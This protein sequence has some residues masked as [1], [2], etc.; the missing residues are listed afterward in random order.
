MFH[1][2]RTW[3]VL[4]LISASMTS[5]SNKSANSSLPAS[6]ST[7]AASGED[8]NSFTA[9]KAEI[10]KATADEK[11]QA[12]LL[13]S[14][15]CMADK[16]YAEALTALQAAQAAKDSEVVRQ[17]IARV[18]GLIL[19]QQSFEETVTDIQAVIDQGQGEQAAQLAILA[20]AQFG[21]GPEAVKLAALKRQADALVA[22]RNFDT[23]KLL[24]RLRVEA[25]VALKENN[26]R[27]AVV[28]YE[29]MVALKDDPV[30]QKQLEVSRTRL[31]KYESAME[32]AG[33][34]RRNMASLDEAVTAY[35]EATQAWDTLQARSEL[36]DVQLALENRRER[37]AVANFEVRGDASL[38]AFG[39]AFADELLPLLKQRYDLVDRGQVDR[40][41]EELKIG[42]D[43]LVVSEQGRTDLGKLTKT[44]YLV[45]GS[46]TPLAGVTVHARMIDL[47]SGLI[48]QTGKIVAPTPEAAARQLPQLAAQ[49]LMS[50]EEKLAY[51]KQQWQLR[52]PAV[53]SMAESSPSLPV[54]NAQSMPAAINYS[55]AR[56]PAYGTLRAEE[57]DQL[58]PMIVT[59]ST[60]PMYAAEQERP[61]RLRLLAIQLELGDNLYCRG[62][63]REALARFQ[64]A[65]ELDPSNFDILT[66]VDQC[67]VYLPPMTVQPV[68]RDRL[69]LLNF[70]VSGDPRIASPELSTWTPE[71]LMPNFAAGY[72]VI[73][74]GE[75]YWMMSRLGLTLGDVIRDSGVRR[76]FGRALG[77]RYLVIGRIQDIGGLT[78][79]TSLL[80][81]EQGWEAGRG[82]VVVHHL[83]ELKL[84]LPELARMTMAS[85]A[86]RTRLEQ[87]ATQ[88]EADYLRAQEAYQRGQFGL[89]LEIAGRLQQRQP[90]NIRIGFLFNQCDDRT[91]RM[92]ME[93]ARL[94]EIERQ[95]GLVELAAR[96]QADLILAAEQAR[97]E[98]MQQGAKWTE[99]DR[100]KQRDQAQTQLLTQARLA[101]QAG[102]FSISLQLFDGALAFRPNDDTLLRE[103]A[104][105]RVRRDEDRRKVYQAE[106]L[107]LAEAERRQRD[108]T[109]AA[110]RQLW[111]NDRQAFAK[112]ALAFQAQQ[113]QQ[114][115]TEHA[116]L[117]DQAKRLKAQRQ[118]DQTAA[119]LEVARRI[120]HDDE[121]ERLLAETLMEQARTQAKAEDA[122]KFAELEKKLGQE[123]ARRRQLE[124]E[125]QR[126]WTLYQAAFKQAQEAYLT[127]NLSIAVAKYQEA[128]RLF[129]TQ[130][131]I[132]GLQSAQAALDQEQQQVA[133]QKREV[134]EKT[135]RSAEV[136][137]WLAA[138]KSAEQARKYDEALAHLNKAKTLDPA[139]IE[140]ITSLAQL[141]QARIK[142]LEEQKS[143]GVRNQSAR[144]KGLLAQAE[145]R[146]KAKQFDTALSILTA[147]QKIALNDQQV[148][149]LISKV[150][151]QQAAEVQAMLAAMGKEEE[152][153]RQVALRIEAEEKAK[154]QASQA[155]KQAETALA[156]G[157]LRAAESALVAA[158]KLAPNDP[159]LIKL[160][161]EL[162]KAQSQASRTV[163]QAD[164]RARLE[165]DAQART[166]DQAHQQQGRIGELLT[167]AQTATAK[168]DYSGAEKLIGEALVL[169][170]TNLTVGRAQR[171]LQKARQNEAQSKASMSAVDK[172]KQEEELAKKKVEFTRL[173]KEGKEALTSEDSEKAAK[174][175][176]EAKALNPDDA[177]AALFLGMAKRDSERA[178]A[179]KEVAR[180]D[181]EDK[182]KRE[183]EAVKAEV[184]LKKKADEELRRKLVMDAE[185]I[186]RSEALKTLN[187]QQY[188]AALKAGKQ[189][190]L[191]KKYDDAIKAFE[192]A[193]QLVPDDKEANAQLIQVK[194]LKADATAPP[195]SKQP[196]PPQKMTPAQLL[197]QASA[198]Q[199]Q[200]KWDAALTL[201]RQALAQNPN[202]QA[203]KAGV[204]QCDFQV[205]L[206]AGRMAL[207]KKDK[208]AAIKA[209]EAAL[210]LAPG[211]VETQKLLKQS[212]ELK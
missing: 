26:L 78:V 114:D 178:K 74:P 90:S 187:K 141:E 203:A 189:A 201:Y 138:G 27:T 38:A 22:A 192:K 111:V 6:S 211:H 94:K 86:E 36:A 56:P 99:A 7:Q 174:L 44:R 54:Y 148:V 84:R 20:L 9:M 60:M 162:A 139:N 154:Q 167:Q 31:N 165:A 176:S 126:N 64:L 144:I 160:Q 17:Q 43:D 152:A 157:D 76:W 164:A 129:Q 10:R 97:Q 182:K 96:R 205:N 105:A 163:A 175:F 156:I 25:E 63:H 72:E 52:Q 104:Q 30:L 79:T 142:A 149:A 210:K 199:K 101:I 184:D 80:D 171:E 206:E 51:D 113:R 28:C 196:D 202:D 124:Q 13:E 143:G 150:K 34:L 158:K 180:K 102:K 194:K 181:E 209:F 195:P 67:L 208:E 48:V 170:P 59:N 1:H 85:A 46:I 103:V 159:A 3:F 68:Q 11:Y 116:R 125:A 77:V 16:K 66:R 117:L 145:G 65:R 75:V 95:R 131:V 168:K 190:V 123:T 121:V 82:Q 8:N 135:H 153:R 212:R 193:L 23:S 21:D 40:I 122:A 58:P 55:T 137:K 19:D 71:N 151:T 127:K 32:R 35:Q 136:A 161:Q 177:D 172:K 45:V 87:E 128:S 5:C 70:F 188:E 119:L 50:D 146:A 37:L 204:T 133:L 130:E 198:L 120:H 41:F 140:V 108:L 42:S 173:M 200:Q 2:N 49:L 185:A 47:K 166:A 100:R 81:T 91:R 115:V 132:T 15:S 88:C 24:E 61:L 12:A 53:V 107:H 98:A 134:E 73:D 62:R 118:Y 147:A 93:Q 69:A 186:K 92:A 183:M 57:F 33:E 29:Q 83:R 106:L 39:S 89:A 110:S 197:S 109:L 169:D 112:N 155:K 18:Q 14:L 207:G 4:I 179:E 191:T